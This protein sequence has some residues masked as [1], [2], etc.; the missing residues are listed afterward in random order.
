MKVNIKSTNLQLTEAIKAYIYKKM[1]MAEK[2]LG[3]NEVIQW[4]FEVE[5]TTNHHHKGDIFR[6]EVNLAFADEYLRTD[7][8][9]DD[10]YKAI[11]EVKD[12]L[13]D[14]IGKQKDKRLAKR[15]VGQKED[16]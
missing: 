11:D 14:L 6:A 8:T 15:R 5:L 10:L 7:Q 13:I 9:A 16:A 1:E 3:K 12:R 4:D 2:Y